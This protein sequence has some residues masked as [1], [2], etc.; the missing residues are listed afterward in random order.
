MLINTR[1]LSFRK[2]LQVTMDNKG[3]YKS[4]PQNTR[5]ENTFLLPHPTLVLLHL[6]KVFFNLLPFSHRMLLR[7][8]LKYIRI[9]L[10]NLTAEEQ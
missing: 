1:V 2:V 10:A 7:S 3:R 9:V 6:K 5:N 4:V 8:T